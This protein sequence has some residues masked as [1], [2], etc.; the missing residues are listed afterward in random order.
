MQDADG[1]VSQEEL[2]DA[3]RTPNGV[4]KLSG[5]DVI[6][7]LESSGL[8]EVTGSVRANPVKVR[9]IA[10]LLSLPVS[11]ASPPV[12]DLASRLIEDLGALL[13]RLHRSS[14]DFFRPDREGGGKRLLP[15]A[16]FSA[17]LALGFE[18]L[19]WQAEREVQRGAGRTDLPLRWNGSADLALV[20]VKIWGRNDYRDVQRQ[21]ES[22]WTSAW[23]PAPSS[24]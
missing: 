7:L 5:A 2:A 16:V 8:V 14:A 9:P 11:S 22:Y 1:E 18:L 20:E 10:S 4:L 19:G 23:P 15:E 6:D 13:A 21:V 17:Y 3:C 24:W 12:T